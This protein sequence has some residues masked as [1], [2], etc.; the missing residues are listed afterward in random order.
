M[1][2]SRQEYW[3]GLP[4][5]PP[6]YFP[7]PGIKP[8]SPTL[9]MDSL[10]AEPPGKPTE[11]FREIDPST[12]YPWG[13]EGYRK[14]RRLTPGSPWG[15]GVL[16][17]RDTSRNKISR[18]RDCHCCL[19][20]FRANGF[21]CLTHIPSKL[22]NSSGLMHADSHLPQVLSPSWNHCR[23]G[24]GIGIQVQGLPS[25]LRPRGASW[26]WGRAI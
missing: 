2:F 6:G 18:T 19:G 21:A 10:P 7:N 8:R 16:G 4:C 9:Q 3:S 1:G 12:W 15:W 23:L 11:P 13:Q 20:R 22:R 25:G 26:A 17:T 24:R 14:P 5:P